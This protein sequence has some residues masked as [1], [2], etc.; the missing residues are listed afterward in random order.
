MTQERV[1]ARVAADRGI[2]Q[3]AGAL[4]AIVLSLV[5]VF[6]PVGFAGGVMGEMFKQFAVTIV[7]AVVLSGIVA[8]TLTPALCAVLLKEAAETHTSGPFGAFNRWFHRMT[9]RY[10]SGVERI[11]HTP[12]RWLA[13]FA[14]ALV[15]L[16]VLGSRVQ[17]A[18]IP[19][20][21]KGYFAIAVQLPDGASLQRTQKVIE[22]IEGFLHEEPAA[23]NMV[24]LAGLDILSRSN[25]PNGATIFMNLATRNERGK[26]D[27][28]E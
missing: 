12:R 20:E 10:V 28:L 11:L 9:D 6:L 5:A 21:D 19:T 3:V 13:M 15:L 8:L 22:R 2:R 18:F 4:V 17:S 26:K 23:R 14:V 16:L 24:A 7:I 25:Q 27:A 1:S